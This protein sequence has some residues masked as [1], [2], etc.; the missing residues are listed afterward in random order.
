M[1]AYLG[2][3]LGTANTL[4]YLKGK[5]II[6]NEPSVIAIDKVSEDILQVGTEAKKMIGKTPANI[7]AIRPLRDGVIADYEVAMAM[8]KYFINQALGGFNL[9]KPTVIVGI[10]TNATEV[11]RRALKNATLDAGA[12][13]AFL[14]EESMATAIGAGLEVEEAS[15]NMAIDIGGGTTEIAVISLG[16]IVLSKSIRIAGDELDQAI[17]NYIKSKYALLIGDRTAEQIKIEIGNCFET[18]EYNNLKIDVI[19]L[20]MLSGLPKR[21]VLSG[22]EI[23]EAISLPISKITENIKLAIE[24]TPPE[25]LADIVNKGIF[26]AGGGAMLKGMKELIEKETKI[27]V[28]VAEEPLTCVARGAGLVVDKINIL[29]NLEKNRAI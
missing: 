9:I 7:V 21:I 8:L 19:G 22:I 2:I 28:V 13:K 29:E 23:R 11:E 5:G 3:D 24:N 6:I 14:I 26:L 25:L 4:V 20:D 16:N 10:P 18:P 15:G 27:R 17:V 1:R 12:G